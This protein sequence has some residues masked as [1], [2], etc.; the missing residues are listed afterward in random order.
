VSVANCIPLQIGLAAYQQPLDAPGEEEAANRGFTSH[1]SPRSML[2]SGQTELGYV[3]QLQLPVLL[4]LN[5][6]QKMH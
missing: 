1:Q 4:L 5:E 2:G 6:V 3:M